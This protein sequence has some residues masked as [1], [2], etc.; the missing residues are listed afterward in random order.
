MNGEGVFNWPDGK[1]YTGMYKDD[2]KNGH[3]TFE[4]PNGCKY[5][6]EWLNNKQHG[7]GVFTL[8]NGEEKA[9]TW[10]N[11]IRVRDPANTHRAS[12]IEQP[13]RAF[14]FGDSHLHP[15]NSHRNSSPEFD[16]HIDVNQSNEI[17]QMSEVITNSNL[18][19][20]ECR[21]QMNQ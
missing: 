7:E 8:S 6:G 13:K 1:K 21:A 3:G 18:E 15:Y 12:Y 20:H 16:N 11:G 19:S 2:Q 9:G 14:D 17:D 4:M 5:T 10:E